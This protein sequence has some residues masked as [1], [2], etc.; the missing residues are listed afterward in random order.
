MHCAVEIVISIVL[1]TFEYLKGDFLKYFYLI[2][3]ILFNT[4]THNYRRLFARMIPFIVYRYSQLWK[5]K[6]S[7]L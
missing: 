3:D 7:P 5:E 2:S 6:I 4:K 1:A